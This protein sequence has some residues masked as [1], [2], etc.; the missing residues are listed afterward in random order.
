MEFQL[1]GPLRL[2]G[3]Q[4]RTI[5]APKVEALLATLLIRANQPVST[6]ELIDELWPDAPPRRA[7]AALHVY[8][9]QLRRNVLTGDGAR[10]HTHAQRYLLTVEESEV[11]AHHLQQL[12]GEGTAALRDDPERALAALT[13]AAALFRGPVLAG[14]PQGLIVGT[15]ARWAEEIRL[16]CLEGIAQCSLRTGRHRELIRDLSR[17]VEE[18]PLNETFREQLMLALHRSGRRAEALEVFQSA[19]RVL[20]DELGLDPRHTMRRLQSAIIE[21]D[22][23]LLAAAG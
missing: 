1:L 9:S 12:H 21:A 11:D 2:A 22:P 3:T 20:R 18:H 19:R 16:E 10:I 5:S 7:R 17:W 6:D 8:I 4:P 23:E 13:G 14:V 15:F